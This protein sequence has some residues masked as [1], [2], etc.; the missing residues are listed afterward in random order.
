MSAL[1]A[2][3]AEVDVADPYRFGGLTNAQCVR[4]RHR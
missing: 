1:Q 4:L 2:L 3:I